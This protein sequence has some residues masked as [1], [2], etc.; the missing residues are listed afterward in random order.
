MGYSLHLFPPERRRDPV[1]KKMDI[2]C[3]QQQLRWSFKFFVLEDQIARDER[4]SP[5]RDALDANHA[6]PTE[7]QDFTQDRRRSIRGSAGPMLARSRP[8]SERREQRS[9][10][11]SV[12]LIILYMLHGYTEIQ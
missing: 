12:L 11:R 8:V 5:F 3:S 4:S 2:K 7:S 9:N 10:V 1:E 6:I